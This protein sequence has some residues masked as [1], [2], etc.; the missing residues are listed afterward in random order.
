MLLKKIAVILTISSIGAFAGAGHHMGEHKRMDKS[1]TYSSSTK[2][3]NPSKHKVKKAQKALNRKGYNVKVDGVMG[4]ETSNALH[5]YQLENGIKP[6]HRLDHSTMV[7]LGVASASSGTTEWQQSSTRR[8][9][10]IDDTDSSMLT[11][12]ERYQSR[13]RMMK[14]RRFNTITA[15]FGIPESALEK[16]QRPSQQKT[17]MR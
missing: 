8:P 4:T 5:E 3:F 13:Y 14:E 16:D 7:S 11:E 6:T 10:S 2:T 1:K 12:D 17:M 9:A 15:G